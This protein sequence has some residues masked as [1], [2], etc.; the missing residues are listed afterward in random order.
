MDVL[1]GILFWHWWILAGVLLILELTSP[2]FFF[3]WLGIWDTLSISF[4]LPI[5][6]S[7]LSSSASLVMS[8]PKLSST[9]VL[10]LEVLFL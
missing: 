8:R 3:L 7:S 10:D 6:G 9:G 4:S 2:V 1:D 5:I